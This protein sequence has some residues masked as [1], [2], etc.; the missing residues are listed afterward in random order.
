MTDYFLL[1]GPC[2]DWTLEGVQ[3]CHAN[4]FWHMVK[5]ISKDSITRFVF[6]LSTFKPV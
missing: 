4:L 5:I 6:L 2:F 3:I 1:I